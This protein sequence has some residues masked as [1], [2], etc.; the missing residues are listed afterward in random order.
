M[1]TDGNQRKR[2]DET[3]TILALYLYFQLPFGQLHSGNPEILRL[4][5]A[6]GRSSSSVAMKL[7]NFASLDPEITG[8]GRKGLSG[9]S[10]LDRA[11]YSEFAEDWTALVG[12]AESKWDEL[13]AD[14]SAG[15]KGVKEDRAAFGTYEGPSTKLA[16]V[17]ARRGQDFFRRAVLANFEEVCCVTGIADARLLTA[18]HIKPWH[19]DEKH[20]HDPTNG[21]L[22]SATFDRAFDCGLITIERSGRLRISKQLTE[23]NNRRTRSFFK[24]FSDIKI[25]QASRFSPN[26]EFIDWH[27]ANCFLDNF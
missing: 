24:E 2:W 7:C 13:V 5:D 21:L 27:N 23:N 6:L 20:R 8:S 17:S 9:A 16:T 22:L 14:S 1:S 15:A 11:I 26:P 12:L 18:S 25:R 4:A 10:K 19:E 3:E